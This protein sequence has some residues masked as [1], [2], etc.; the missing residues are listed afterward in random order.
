MHAGSD[1][2]VAIYLQSFKYFVQ[3]YASND[4]DEIAKLYRFRDG[5]YFKMLKYRNEIKEKWTKAGTEPI[6]I[7]IH[8]RRSM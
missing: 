2:Q 5:A 3:N 4:D 7:G 6:L 1:I 8:N